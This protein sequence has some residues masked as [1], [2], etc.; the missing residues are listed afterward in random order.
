[1]TSAVVVDR[2]PTSVTLA[3]SQNPSDPG[4]AVALSA[5][6]TPSFINE[7]SVEFRDGGTLLST[8]PATLDPRGFSRALLL[9][10]LDPGQHTIT[11]SYLGTIN[12]EPSVSQPL[13]QTVNTA[14]FATDVSP[15]SLMVPPGGSNSFLFYV[16]PVAGFS[17]SVSLTCTG[18]PAFATRNLNPA[19]LNISGSTLTSTVTLS[20]NRQVAGL[21]HQPF[22]PQMA[23]FVVTCSGIAAVLGRR[24]RRGRRHCGLFGVVL[25]IVVAGSCSGGGSGGSSQSGRSP[26]TAQITV[27]AASSANGSLVSHSQQVTVTFQ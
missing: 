17:G 3:S 23:W 22:G 6:M 11:A 12:F 7:G 15:G 5:F 14:G 13:V 20:S 18:A 24:P 1:M 2:R 25:L 16:S 26:T 21:R 10:N 19:T 9:V 4:V 8:S 27:T